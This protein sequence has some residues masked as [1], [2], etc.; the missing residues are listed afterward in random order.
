MLLILDLALRERRTVDSQLVTYIHTEVRNLDLPR[1][2]LLVCECVSHLNNIEDLFSSP[3]E[4]IE[5]LVLQIIKNL[6]ASVMYDISNPRYHVLTFQRFGNRI[7]LFMSDQNHLKQ[8]DL[9]IDGMVK[10]GKH[11]NNPVITIC[12]YNNHV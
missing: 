12:Y 5:Q 1:M 6:A 4:S 2:N 7:T 11:C 10:V 9:L 3:N 8:L